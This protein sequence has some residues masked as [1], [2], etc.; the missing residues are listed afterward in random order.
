MERYIIGDTG[1]ERVGELPI[2]DKLMNT[3]PFNTKFFDPLGIHTKYD[4]ILGGEAKGAVKYVQAGTDNWTT[5]S[6]YLRAAGF[7]ERVIDW[8]TAQVML[9]TNNLKSRVSK[10]D[11]NLS[12]IKYNKHGVP[13]TP[14]RLSPEGDHYAHYSSPTDW[15]R[16]FKRVL[17]LRNVHTKNSTGGPAAIDAGSVEDYAHRLKVNGY[18]GASEY[19]YLRILKQL[20]GAKAGAPKFLAEQKEIVKETTENQAGGNWF[21]KL[22]WYGKVG[23]VAGG[24]LGIKLIVSK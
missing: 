1:I 3:W 18:Y 10:D 22:P 4:D 9:E 13:Q 24:L 19:D 14:G 2:A 7:P 17:S 6:N 20:L 5:V 23:V 11:N 16:D 12:G 15:G 8:A 21:T